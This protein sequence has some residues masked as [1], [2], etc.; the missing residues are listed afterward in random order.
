VAYAFLAPLAGAVVAEDDAVSTW[1]S[2]EGRPTYL[3][4]SLDARGDVDGDG[5]R[6][7]LIGA[8]YAGLGDD[9]GRAY[10]QLGLISGTIEVSTLVEFGGPN[11]DA[12][13]GDAVRFVPDWDDDGGD[14]IAIGAGGAIN[15]AGVASGIVGVVSSGQLR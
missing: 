5:A 2:T 6:D 8:P 14:E 11:V 15:S 10:L 12:R 9:S 4:A 3:G 7:V 1:V 13:V